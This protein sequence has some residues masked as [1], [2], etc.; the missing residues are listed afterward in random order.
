MIGVNS[1]RS[2]SEVN[3]KLF[4]TGD[5]S[6]A[7]LFENT[8]VV[9]RSG[10]RPTVIFGGLFISIQVFCIKT[11]PIAYADASVWSAS[12]SCGYTQDRGAIG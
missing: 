9:L 12:V 8:V 10:Q 2:I 4:Y 1:E 5:D 6:E 7:L 3:M 11:P